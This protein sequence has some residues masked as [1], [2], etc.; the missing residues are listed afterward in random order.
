VCGPDRDRSSVNVTRRRLGL[1]N[2]ARHG[3]HAGAPDLRDEF[4]AMMFTALAAV[5]VPE[6][7]E[8]VVV[9][10]ADVGVVLLPPECP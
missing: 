6:D 7:P 5:V 3:N 9:A 10:L 4:H 2:A 8:D 1:R